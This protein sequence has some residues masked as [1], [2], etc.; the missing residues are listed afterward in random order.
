MLIIINMYMWIDSMMRI[1][2]MTLDAKLVEQVDA[3]AKRTGTTRSAFTRE[4]LTE[5]LR[6]RYIAALEE[7]ERLSVER[8]PLQ[9]DEIDYIE[10]DLAWGDPWEER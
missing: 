10:E 7:R 6:R 1:V 2:Q 9:P 4:A 5:A 8:L 3:E